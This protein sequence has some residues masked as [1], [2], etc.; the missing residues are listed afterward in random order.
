[1]RAPSELSMILTSDLFDLEAVGLELFERFVEIHDL[2][3][4]KWN[5]DGTGEV[6]IVYVAGDKMYEV[7]YDIASETTVTGICERVQ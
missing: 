4:Y 1:M 2:R 7:L 3:K 6:S 5:A